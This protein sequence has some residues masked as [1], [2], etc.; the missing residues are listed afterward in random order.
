MTEPSPTTTPL[1]DLRARADKAMV[2]DNGRVRPGRRLQDSP[3]A[4]ATGQVH[5]LAYLGA[6]T[7]GGPRCPPMVPEVYVGADIDVAGH[8]HEHWAAT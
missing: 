1:N 2:L 4:H 5:V 3:K 8:E 7:H 6:G